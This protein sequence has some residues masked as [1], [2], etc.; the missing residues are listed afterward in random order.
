MQ[1]QILA[2]VP[3]SLLFYADAAAVAIASI[4]PSEVSPILGDGRDG[5]R[6]TCVNGPTST[7]V[8]KFQTPTKAEIEELEGETVTLRPSSSPE[9]H[10]FI[11]DQ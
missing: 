3:F 11:N 4:T 8:G 9:E 1:L 10:A 7:A 2:L 6:I 5:P